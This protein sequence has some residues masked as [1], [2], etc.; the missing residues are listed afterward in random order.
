MKAQ[1]QKIILSS[2][3]GKAI[4]LLIIL[5]DLTLFLLTNYFSDYFDN[6]RRLVLDVARV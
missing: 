6:S 5:N 1:K 3:R 4:L 2:F